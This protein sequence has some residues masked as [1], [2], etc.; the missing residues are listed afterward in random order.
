MRF[1]QSTHLLMHWLTYSIGN[2]KSGEL[3]YNYCNSNNLIQMVNFS[4]GYPECC[5]QSLILL[6]LFISSDPS[7]CSAVAFPPLEN[8]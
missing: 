6:D 3:Y 7:I 1:S 8:F 4:A 2:D 5:S